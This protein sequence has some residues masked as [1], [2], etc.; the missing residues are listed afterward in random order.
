M[1]MTKTIKTSK[2]HFKYY[3]WKT[4]IDIIFELW[5]KTS[6]LY[7]RNVKFLCLYKSHRENPFQEH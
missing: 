1:F 2:N 7:T 6:G 5:P 4:K 3:H